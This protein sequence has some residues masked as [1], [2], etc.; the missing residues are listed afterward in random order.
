MQLKRSQCLL[1]VSLSST[2]YERLQHQISLLGQKF[3][4]SVQI[5]ARLG[6]GRGGDEFQNQP[7]D[8]FGARLDAGALARHTKWHYWTLFF[9]LRALALRVM[10]TDKEP[11]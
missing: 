3:P 5:D 7:H 6:P 10:A 4:V 11:S 1:V 9:P 2:L 8:F